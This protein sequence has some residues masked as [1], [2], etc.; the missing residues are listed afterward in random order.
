MIKAE[1]MATTMAVVPRVAQALDQ[2]R[3]ARLFA[4]ARAMA[5]ERATGSAYRASSLFTQDW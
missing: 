1:V 5:I 2:H 4:A 3:E